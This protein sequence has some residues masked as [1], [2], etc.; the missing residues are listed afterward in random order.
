M[1][2]SLSLVRF[3]LVRLRV[4]RR[5]LRKGRAFLRNVVVVVVV[6]FGWGFVVVVV[7]CW[8]FVCGGGRGGIGNV[9]GGLGRVRV[10]GRWVGGCCEGAEGRGRWRW[11]LW[12]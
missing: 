2:V 3:L 10:R 12:F 8:W 4:R 1:S 9:S 7:C 11:T 5:G 6:L